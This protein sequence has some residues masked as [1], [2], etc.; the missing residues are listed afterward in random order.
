MCAKS[1]QSCP[2]PFATPWTAA[3]QA[4]LAIGFS[5]QEYWN[6]LPFPPPGDLPGSGKPTCLMSPALARGFFTT[7]TT[8]EAPSYNISITKTSAK[9]SGFLRKKQ[10]RLEH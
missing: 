1:L 6:G 5:R 10:N 7:S 4:P 3:R 2:R 9:I 8:W